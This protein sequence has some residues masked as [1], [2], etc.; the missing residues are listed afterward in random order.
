MRPH[1]ITDDSG[2]PAPPAAR[3]SIEAALSKVSADALD[4]LP[5]PLT[6][7]VRYA[8]AGEGKR[9]RPILSQ[10]I[11]EACGGAGDIASIALSVELIHTY[12][13]VHD[14]L[15]CMDDDDV[16]RGRPTVHRK[17]SARDA[18]LAAAAL[19]P[20]AARSIFRAGREL[21]Y[22]EAKCGAIA[23]TVLSS[24]GAGG[25]IGGQLRDLNAEGQSLSLD[26][27]ES[28]HS[29][30]TGELI[31]ASAIIGAIAADADAGTLAAVEKFAR[32]VGLA[33]QIMDDVLDETSSTATLGKTAGRDAALG[34][35]TYVSLLGVTRAREH[36]EE[37]VKEGTAALLG[38][39]I[40]TADLLEVANFILARNA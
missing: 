25:M 40:L 34:K 14:D 20:I 23:R 38:R 31:L 32:S 5:E 30:K 39:G 11:Y 15:P 37:V 33:F 7:V 2:S 8:L 16:R 36:A 3:D 22:S 6:T 1:P 28:L 9:F 10:Y 27:M 24:A 35:S 18:V 17:F 29:A 12:S 21:G 4:G 26:E 13:L 19:I